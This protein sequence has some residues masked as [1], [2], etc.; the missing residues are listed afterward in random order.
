MVR[1]TTIWRDPGI[2]IVPAIAFLVLGCAVPLVLFFVETL[3]EI[4]SFAD[5]VD[6][7]ATTISSRAVV[8]AMFTTNWIA[9]L[10]TLLTLFAGYPIAYV[11][12]N[13]DRLRFTLILF[14]IIVPYFTSVIVRTYSWMV[15]LG[16]NG[17]IN[18]LLLGSGL[19]DH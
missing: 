7:A 16:R 13:S 12:A 18:Q 10:V 17:I 8:N 2:L 4:G 19:V 9:L 5:I 3:R 15:L 6:E 1:T 14:C 11:L